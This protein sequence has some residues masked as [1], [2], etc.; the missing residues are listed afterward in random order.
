MSKAVL[1]GTLGLALLLAVGATIA[2]RDRFDVAA[3][4]AW[5]PP[6]PCCSW[7]CTL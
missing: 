6:G 3:L 2:L 7:P 4:Q 1:R 5:V